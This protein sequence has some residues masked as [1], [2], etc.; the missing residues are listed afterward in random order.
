MADETAKTTAPASPITKEQMDKFREL[1]K[2]INE[3]QKSLKPRKEAIFDAVMENVD[4]DEVKQLI[5]FSGKESL[6][7]SGDYADQKITVSFRLGK[8]DEE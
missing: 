3:F 8:G 1:Q 6:T 4:I 5:E 2:K 7:V